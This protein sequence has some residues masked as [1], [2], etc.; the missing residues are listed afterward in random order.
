M[1]VSTAPPLLRGGPGTSALEEGS[2][3]EFGRLRLERLE[4]CRGEM[5]RD[6]L[7]ALLLG[8]EANIH[9]VSGARRLWLG[10][11]RP[12]V[13]GCVVLREGQLHLM[14]NWDDGVPGAIPRQQ[15]FGISWNPL[16][17]ADVLAGIPE[18]RGVR[19]VGIDGMTP[20]MAALV[21]TALPEAE[22]VDCAP[23]L[24]RARRIKSS[25]ELGC[26]MTAI[27]AAES[28]MSRARQ[29]LVPGVTEGELFGHFAQRLGELGLT[30]PTTHG[31][32][33]VGEKTGTKGSDPGADRASASSRPVGPGDLVVFDS[34]VLYAGYEG[35]M[36]RT[37]LCPGGT[38]SQ[39]DGYQR[40]RRRAQQ[41]QDAVIATCKAGATAA[42]ILDAYQA[43]GEVLPVPPVL[44]GLGLGMEDP[45]IGRDTPDEA[46]LSAVLGQ[47]MVMAVQVHVHEEGAGS[48][49]Q[50]D[51]VY[52]AQNGPVVLTH[53][54]SRDRGR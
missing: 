33:Y 31:T 54:A 5:A 11:T 14:S 16:H 40:L 53:Q 8:D 51:V 10:Y 23:T 30:T 44:N 47:G 42:E 29:R 25:D 1:N 2:R 52:I 9:Y 41:L 13:P 50:R 28:A 48:Y 36:A 24:A 15:L 12:Y 37:W 22:L 18:L 38:V 27:A 26:I 19:R 32:F 49:A 20:L 39:T 45:I 43:S 17:Y 46:R 3:V 6:G 4:R 34:G 7:D 35:S 21:G